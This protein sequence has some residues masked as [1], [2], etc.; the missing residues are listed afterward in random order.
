MEGQKHKKREQ[1]IKINEIKQQKLQFQQQQQ[2]ESANGGNASSA[3]PSAPQPVPAPPATDA[4]GQQ[5]ATGFRF[6]RVNTANTDPSQSRFSGTRNSLVIR[7]ELCEVACTGRDAYTAHLRGVKHQKTL[8]LHQKLGKPIPPDQVM[9]NAPNVA[10]AAAAGSETAQQEA[11]DSQ[12]AEIKSDANQMETE[13]S[14]MDQDTE[15]YSS[16]LEPIGKEYIETRIEGKILSFY[17]KLCECQFNDPNAKDMHTK[18]R[19]HRLAYKKKVDPNLVVDIKVSGSAR[20]KQMAIGGL[21]RNGVKSKVPTVGGTLKPLMGPG[22]DIGQSGQS[23]SLQQFMS[24]TV[25]YLDKIFHLSIYSCFVEE[26]KRA[27]RTLK[28]FVITKWTFNKQKK[29]T[30]I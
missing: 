1:S 19:R 28:I 6:P 12:Q 18:G 24:Q 23:Q 3:D 14:G 13:A 16:S 30:K 27:Y 7:C 15:D 2:S 26:Y 10:A 11:M 21:G 29:K 17:C 20:N 8:K 25:R 4:S 22:S 9:I 5:P